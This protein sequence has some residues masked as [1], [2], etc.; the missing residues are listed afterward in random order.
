MKASG[1]YLV[2]ATVLLLLLRGLSQASGSHRDYVLPKLD[3]PVVVD[4]DLSDPI[5]KHALRIEEFFEISPGDNTVP[6]VRTTGY[7][8]Y[9]SQYLY[10]A[11]HCFDPHPEEIRAAFSDRDSVLR[12][13]DFVQF[14]LDTKDD[15]KSSFIF[16]VNPRGIPADAIFSEATGLDDFSPDFSFETDAKI[17]EDGWTAEFRIPLSTLRYGQ[18]PVQQWGITFYRNYPRQFRRQMTSLPIPRG[19]NCWLC[20]DIK[21]TDI[22]DL[23]KSRYLLLVPFATALNESLR[24]SSGES[25]YDL[26][27]GLD[28]KWIPVNNLTLD[29]TLNP[30]FAQVEADVPQIAVNNRFALFYPEKRSFFLERA[31]LLLTPLQAVYTRTITSPAWGARTTGE[32]GN[33]AYTF[34]LTEDEGGGSQIIPG[35]VFSD[36]APQIGHSIAAIG[37]MR[38]LLGNTLA[39]FVLTDRESDTGFN[40]LIGPDLQW[41]P[42]ASNQFTAQWLASNTKTSDQDATNDSALSLNWQY[43][44]S[45]KFLQLWYQRLGHDFRADNGFIPQV[46][47]ERKAASTGYQFYPENWLRFIQPGFTWD[48]SVEIGDRPV[49]RSTFPSLLLRGKWNSTMNFEYHIQE[50]VRTATKLNEYSFVAFALQFQPTRFLSSLDFKGNL[51]E[52]VDVVN[53]RV[54][55]GRSL[56]VTATLRPGIHLNTE[57]VAERQVLDIESSRLF[58]ADVAQLKVTHNFSP[59]MFLRVIGQ[60]ERIHRN[61]KLYSRP[62]DADEGN[63]NGS[64]LF[65][66]KLNWQTAFYAGYDNESLLLNGNNYQQNGS[67]FFFKFAYAFER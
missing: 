67:H 54:G 43:S 38:Y 15:E 42:N 29:A 19:A 8:G 65:G 21:L 26:N 46:G 39:G 33:A 4:G 10:A 36:L 31:D 41:R 16:R 17:V 60:Y 13:Q 55:T 22:T 23:P 34:L 47:I 61:V 1:G 11:V 12:D 59:R 25:S 49:S 24:A 30:D 53:E 50:Q 57:V 27:G 56:G 7:L 20:Y 51:G 32:A 5:W 28:V 48:S 52:Q 35:P 37:R 3:G 9:D 40:R 44:T 45:T 64:I 6:V 63:L 14:D 18:K 2:F 58:T 66:Y 62:I